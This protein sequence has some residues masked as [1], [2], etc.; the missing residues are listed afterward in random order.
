MKIHL[1]ITTALL[2]AGPALAQNRAGRPVMRDAATHE[3]LTEVTRKAA[4][5]KTE[6][7]FQPKEGK[8]PSK[9]NRP[10]DLIGRSDIL[11]YNG[12]ATLVP[13]RA[14]LHIPKSMAGRIGMQDGAK[15]V[16]WPDFIA[17]NR[18][19]ITTSTV[20]RVQAEGNEPLSEATVKS[21]AKESR[22]VIAVYQE[23][24]ISVLPL[25]VPEVPTAA[26]Q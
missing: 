15:I 18:A 10:A 17:G 2:A 21:F 20:S 12:I 9:E 6:P 23:C 24:P 11:C 13:K 4:A 3:Q 5:Q 19:W 8:D 7:V 26:A 16:T 14:V 22:V 25:K 1:L